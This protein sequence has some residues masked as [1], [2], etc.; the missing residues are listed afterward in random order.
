MMK[1]IALTLSVISCLLFAACEQT[2]EVVKIHTDFG[3]ILLYLYDATPM[4]KANFFK[5][6]KS[7]F[8]DG[9]TFH[10]IIKNFMIQG[11][12]PNS[13]DNDPNNDGEGGPPFTG[14]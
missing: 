9:T 14:E 7:G 8:Y 10:R 2:V 4:H 6:A 11:G 12:D 13:K 3:D 5:L 1:R